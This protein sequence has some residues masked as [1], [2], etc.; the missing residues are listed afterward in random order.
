MTEATSPYLNRPCRT[1]KEAQL[2]HIERE[3]RELERGM[4]RHL[5]CSHSFEDAWERSVLYWRRCGQ[6]WARQD[7]FIV[8]AEL[9]IILAVLVPVLVIAASELADFVSVLAA[10]M[11]ENKAILCA[12]MT[13]PPPECGP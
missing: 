9:C 8:S 7:G 5:A 13:S 11:A 10:S 2:D 3:I 1:L 4:V 6:F 12:S